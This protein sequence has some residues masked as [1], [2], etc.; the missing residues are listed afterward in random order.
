MNEELKSISEKVKFSLKRLK[1]I[2]LIALSIY[3]IVMIGRF[4]YKVFMLTIK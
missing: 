1:R 2:L 4:A 3:V